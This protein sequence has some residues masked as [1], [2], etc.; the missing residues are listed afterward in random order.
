M[1]LLSFFSSRPGTAKPRAPSPKKR[2]PPAEPRLKEAAPTGRAA[3]EPARPRATATRPARVEQRTGAQRSSNT[4][5][6]VGAEGAGKHSEPS[7]PAVIASENDLAQKIRFERA[8]NKDLD[9]LPAIASK[10][11]PVLLDNNTV[12]LLCLPEYLDSDEADDVQKLV[13]QKQQRPM[14][15][16][17]RVVVAVPA[18]LNAIIREHINKETLGSRRKILISPERTAMMGLLEDMLE[19]G[20]K[21][22]AADI[23]INVFDTR[24]YSEV[25]FSVGGKYVSV[26]QFANMPTQQLQELLR[27]AFME[28][29]GAAQATFQPLMEQQGRSNHVLKNGNRVMLRWATLAA[30][31]GVSVTMRILHLDVDE[32]GK[33]FEE[34]GYL[35]GQEQMMRRARMTNGGAVV[36]AGIVG[37]GKS[38]SLAAKIRGIPAYRKIITLEDPVEYLLRNAIQNT[39]TWVSGVEDPFIE[40][41][42]A[43]KRSAM[44][45]LV[46]GEIRDLVTGRAFMDLASSGTNLYT[47]THTGRAV[48]IPDRLA[49]DV[50]GVSRDFLASNGVLKL[51]VYQAL[52][53]RLCDCKHDFEYLVRE[54][55]EDS[56]GQFRGGDYWRSYADR[57]DRLYGIDA[58]TNVKVRNPDGCSVCQKQGFHELFG[59]NDRTVVAEMIEPAIDDHAL[60]LIRRADNAGLE[61]YYFGRTDLDYTSPDM[62]GKSAMD[63]AVYK[64]YKGE[65]D[66]RE[67]EPRFKA[68][69]TVEIARE[70][71]KRRKA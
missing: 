35:P 52:V 66:P 55:G 54:G 48:Q 36:L 68:F 21:H 9:L 69:E 28:V 1:G 50:I 60:E 19:W 27:V 67:I 7:A 16:P 32:K 38:T 6:V 58:L 39:I 57:I 43:V 26:G 65:L 40:K 71:A 63:C 44:H 64:A 45:D 24:P 4:E 46:I 42:K 49:S 14:S 51:L 34:L 8:L 47:T 15:D 37:S 61:R 30:D 2:V 17:A 23:H 31:A 29:K 12:I 13:I 18:L 20:A 70:I 25:K 53:P 22:N 41:L 10:V 33:T 5:R 62:N 11:C 56:E 59:L 3:P